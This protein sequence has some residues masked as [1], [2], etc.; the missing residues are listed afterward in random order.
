MTRSS[1]YVGGPRAF[2][3]CDFMAIDGA[4]RS[5]G[6]IQKGREPAEGDGGMFAVKNV[7]QNTLDDGQAL[8]LQRNTTAALIRRS[9]R[10]ISSP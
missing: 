1:P 5:H 2:T 10:W 6:A 7:S 9:P 4:S 8:S 3:L